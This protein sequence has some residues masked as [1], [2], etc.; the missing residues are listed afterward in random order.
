[1]KKSL[2]SLLFLGLLV[3]SGRAAGASQ[4][5]LVFRPVG[6]WV[7]PASLKAEV[8][9]APVGTPGPVRSPQV[10]S[11][12][13]RFRTDVAPRTTWQVSVRGDGFWA[14]PQIVFVGEE[15]VSRSVDVLP[16]GAITGE[17]R[18]PPSAKLPT[19]LL[20]RLRPAPGAA[21][22]FAEIEERCPLDS[23]NRFR[24]TIPAGSFD[25]RLRAA[26][27]VTQYRWGAQVPRHRALA[28]GTLV[29]RP[30]AS[31]VGWID[32]PSRDFQFNDCTVELSPLVLGVQRTPA[33][34]ER[35]N[36]LNV[37]AKANSRGFF[38]LAG[39]D[40]GSYS[41]T[42]RHPQYAPSRVNPVEVAAGTETE[43]KAVRLEP[44][45]EL[46]V[47][48]SPP[49]DSYGRI[50]RLELLRRGVT[51]PGGAFAVRAS[52]GRGAARG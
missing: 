17:V 29:L 23:K 28:V 35:R 5:E 19:T 46:T 18:A 37:K 36:S 24:C 1:M 14:P 2:R 39:M 32:A 12:A 11:L 31:I 26:G 15:E 16:A 44:P 10:V 13:E 22:V 50:W 7:F 45:A 48:V 52:R 8:T 43:L 21:K 6:G 4:L 47:E 40:A 38:E 27:F 30:G 42:V 49:L 51:H 33:N 34:V 25:L 41:V 3:A 9:L 20:L